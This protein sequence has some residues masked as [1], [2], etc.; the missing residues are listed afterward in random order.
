MQCG[1]LI[2]NHSYH[3]NFLRRFDGKNTEQLILLLLMA[4][5]TTTHNTLGQQ[6]D[7]AREC[8]G[9]FLLCLPGGGP[10]Q[11]HEC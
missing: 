1:T 11:G 4:S 6:P 9:A 10:K 5:E 8:R 2:T 3:V 7:S